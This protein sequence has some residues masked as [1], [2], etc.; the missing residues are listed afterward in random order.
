MNRN[1]ISNI[2]GIIVVLII[3]SLFWAVAELPRISDK[4]KY[5][6]T[7]NSGTRDYTNEIVERDGCATYIDAVGFEK[8]VCGVYTIIKNKK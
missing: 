4:Y 8:K 3:V 6:I 2:M 1:R 5:T 7:L